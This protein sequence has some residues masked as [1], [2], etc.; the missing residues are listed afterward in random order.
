MYIL[1]RA[2]LMFPLSV[3]GSLD[4]PHARHRLRRRSTRRL[5]RP[6]LRPRVLQLCTKKKQV[7][8]Y[9]YIIY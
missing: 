4:G 1:T 7:R 9:M 2:Q 3:P 5:T 6:D 8:R